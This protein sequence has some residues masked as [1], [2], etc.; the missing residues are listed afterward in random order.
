MAT[1]LDCNIMP[2]VSEAYCFLLLTKCYS[3]NIYV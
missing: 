1:E 3:R 2:M